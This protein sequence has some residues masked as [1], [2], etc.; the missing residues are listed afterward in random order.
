MSALLR[1]LLWLA[2]QAAVPAWAQ[3]GNEKTT[4]PNAPAG[5]SV[6]GLA[7]HDFVYAG[8][9]KE[10]RMFL[11]RDGTVVWALRSWAAPADLGPATTIRLL[12]KN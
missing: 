8:E 7:H 4:A 3:N 5:L 11:V 10:D 1:I 12:D 6:K 9:A 2:F